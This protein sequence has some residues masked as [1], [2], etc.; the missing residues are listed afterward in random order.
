MTLA[1]AKKECA[2]LGYTLIKDRE[3]D[4]YIVKP[5]GARSDDPRAYFTNDL[6]DAVGTARA[7]AAPDAYTPGDAVEINREQGA[8]RWEP[9]TYRA[10]LTEETA[11][12]AGDRPHLV[13]IAGDTLRF[14]NDRVRPAR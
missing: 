8:E 14:P 12:R 1:T 2:A 10:T 4:Q 5:Q 9:A 3:W 7:M 11:I 6:D 13:L